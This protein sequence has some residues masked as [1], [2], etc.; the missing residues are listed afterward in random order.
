MHPAVID[1]DALEVPA[2]RRNRPGFKPIHVDVCAQPIHV[3]RVLLAAHVLIVP[4][5]AIPRQDS[6]R[7]SELIAQG[8]EAHHVLNRYECEQAIAASA[9]ELT[10]GK[11]LCDLYALPTA[12]KLDL[13]KR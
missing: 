11:V 7:R 4:C 1:P 5:A 12:K 13:G 2:V 9:F 8:L 3:E 10:K 6:D